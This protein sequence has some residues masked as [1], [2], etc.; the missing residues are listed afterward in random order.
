MNDRE[1]ANE[2][3]R[4]TYFPRK[5]KG[6][7]SKFFTKVFS[8]ARLVVENMVSDMADV[9][10]MAVDSVVRFFSSIFFAIKTLGVLTLLAF[11]LLM[12]VLSGCATG[13]FTHVWCK[14]KTQ[15][16]SFGVYTEDDGKLKVRLYN[17]EECTYL[18]DQNVVIEHENQTVK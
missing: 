1:F 5:E 3:N 14:S 7:F 12:L 10:C 9:V 8:K 18:K 6:M 13:Y 15:D 2:L 11:F 17:M 4:L 16:V